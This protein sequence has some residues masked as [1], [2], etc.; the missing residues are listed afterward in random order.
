MEQRLAAVVQCQQCKAQ[1]QIVPSPS[2]STS[3]EPPQPSGLSSRLEE[4]FFILEGAL[5]G[6]NPLPGGKKITKQKRNFPP[7]SL[8]RSLIYFFPYYYNNR[9]SY[10]EP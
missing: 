2:L 3:T 5:A 8:V 1:L 4:S 6:R 7:P 9:Y 10:R